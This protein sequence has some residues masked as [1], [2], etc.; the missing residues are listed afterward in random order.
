MTEE[1][2]PPIGGEEPKK[3][4]LKKDEPHKA[5]NAHHKKKLKMNFKWTNK[6]G[7]VVAVIVL[8]LVGGLAY[9]YKNKPADIGPDGAKKAVA[10]FVNNNLLQP[11]TKATIKSV[12]KDGSLY[13]VSINVAGQDVDTY[14]TQDGKTFFPQAMDVASVGGANASGQQA[15]PAAQ[16]IPKSDVPDVKL[17]VMSY[18][19]YGTQM[20]KGI[21]PVVNALGSK[22]KFSLEFV[23]YSMHNDKSTNDRKELDE[24]L[25]QYC[26]EKNQP[27][28]LDAYLSCF[29]NKGQGTESSCMASA[30]VDT[31][32]VA[33]CVAQTDNQ[34]NVTKDW[35]DQSTW[36][37]QFPPF[38]VNKDENVKYNVQG[39]P[40]LVINGVEAQPSGRD[41][42]SLLSTICSAF[43]NTPKECSTKLSSTAPAPGFGGGTASG[44][45][46]ASCT[47]N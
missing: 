39:S 12:A 16:D 17:F 27:Q 7:L 21:L 28:K 22:I 46:S 47:T 24:N 3:E 40:T 4:E 5:E 13:K 15:A 42:A 23:D 29:L 34:F 11:G 26:I 19:P 31:T 43:N 45:G 1:K 2:N 8:A 25:R 6:T 38:D 20:E 41:S 36:V 9:Y 10:D 30:G 35:N 32:Q 33:S 18:C 37:G 14:M 44:S